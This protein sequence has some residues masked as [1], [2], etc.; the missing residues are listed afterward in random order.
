MNTQ[1]QFTFGN[2]IK[3][4]SVKETIVAYLW[5][6]GDWLAAHEL[7]KV[8]TPYGRIGNSGDVRA[9]ELARNECSEKL[10]NKVERADGRDIGRDSRFTYYRYKQ[11]QQRG[12]EWGEQ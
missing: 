8:E 5:E 7:I 6:R 10:Q 1:A 9:R 2:I 12:I 4:N 3:C 11:P